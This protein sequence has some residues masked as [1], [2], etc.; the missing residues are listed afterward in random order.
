MSHS[1]TVNQHP[2]KNQSWKHII[3][4]NT[5]NHLP[6]ELLQEG[7]YIARQMGKGNEVDGARNEY[8]VW[9][10]GERREMEGKSLKGEKGR[11]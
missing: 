6:L 3:F 1:L 5:I 2:R 9:V 4:I 11:K 7:D 10:R 8:S